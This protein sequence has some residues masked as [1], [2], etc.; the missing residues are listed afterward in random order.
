[1]EETIF[2]SVAGA[3]L[4]VEA[5]ELI[6]FYCIF[7]C[8][9]NLAMQLALEI[10]NPDNEFQIVSELTKIIANLLMNMFYQLKETTFI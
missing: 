5:G 9:I 6:L 1:M 3:V 2:E 7:G 8:R 4:L 10:K